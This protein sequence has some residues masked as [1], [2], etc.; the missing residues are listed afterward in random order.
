MSALAVPKPGSG[1]KNERRGDP[2]RHSSRESQPVSERGSWERNYQKVW[3]FA[4]GRLLEEEAKIYDDR[5]RIQGSRNGALGF[6]GRDLLEFMIRETR[7]MNGYLKEMSIR[8]YA[9][10]LKCSVQTVVNAMKALI[11]AGFLEKQRRKIVLNER[12]P[13]GHRRCVQD[14]NIYRLKRPAKAAA[15][16]RYVL[17]LR[18]QKQESQAEMAARVRAEANAQEMA[19]ALMQNRPPRL[20]SEPP[21]YATL[22]K[23]AHIGRSDSSS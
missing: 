19:K 13:R 8:G 22:A 4:E 9:T 18:K 6:R 3:S 5:T 20:K 11:E 16:R 21:H 15:L 10:M 7:R 23:F 1:Y 2:V 12:G 14:K 17:G